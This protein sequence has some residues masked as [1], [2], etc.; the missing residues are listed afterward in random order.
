MVRIT[1]SELRQSRRKSSTI[2]PV[3]R[4]PNALSVTSP[5]IAFTTNRDWS[6]SSLIST[7]SGAAAFILGRASRTRCMTASVEASERFVTG[8]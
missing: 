5:L 3:S 1:I 2:T 7:S 6:N 4:A 8:M